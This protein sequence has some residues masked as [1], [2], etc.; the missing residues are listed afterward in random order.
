VDTL[1]WVRKHGFAFA[2]SLLLDA[3]LTACHTVGESDSAR[4]NC[5]LETPPASSGEMSAEGGQMRIYPRSTE[6]AKHYSG[7]QTVWGLDRSKSVWI[8]MGERHYLDG[9]VTELRVIDLGPGEKTCRYNKGAL[10]DGPASCPTFEIINKR[11]A[12]LP[13]GCLETLAH[14]TQGARE[15]CLQQYK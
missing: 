5:S 12:S 15:P 1:R 2:I 10:V 13:P 8:F 7:C 11:E 4:L 6:M 9:S 3:L 14:S